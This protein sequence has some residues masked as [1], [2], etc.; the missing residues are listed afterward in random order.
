MQTLLAALRN[1]ARPLLSE[2]LFVSSSV[3]LS[4]RFSVTLP[5]SRTYTVQDIEIHF[6]VTLHDKGMFVVPLD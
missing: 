4:V 1:E 2:C 6:T 3:R 5:E